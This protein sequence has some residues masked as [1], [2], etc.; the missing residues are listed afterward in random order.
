[1]IAARQPVAPS[2]PD[3][4]SLPGLDGLRAAACLMVFGV[5]FGQITAQQGH[6]GP[7]DLARALANGNTGVALFFALSG[8]LLSLP[9][10]PTH[11]RPQNAPAA[12]PFYLRRAARILPAYALCLAALV[13]ANR[14]WQE[15][16]GALDIL[17][18]ALMV[19]NFR[20]ASTL[21]INPVF[22][23][24]AVE[25]QFYLLLPLLFA[26][27]RRLGR[28]TAWVVLALLV[29]AAWAL[30][31]LRLQ[32]AGAPTAVI[33]YS[34]GAHLP[35]FLL[36]VLTGGLFASHGGGTARGAGW[37]DGAVALVLLALAVIL[38]TPLDEVLQVP[39]GRYN[40]PFVPALLCVLI[41]LVPSSRLGQ[42]LFDSTPMRL[43][44]AVSYG[45]YLFH[46]PVLNVTARAM[47]RVGWPIGTHTLLYGA[48]SLA[49]TLVV[50]TLSYRLIERPVMRAV[51]ARR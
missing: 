25:V 46:L 33:T 28:P 14:H 9:F 2:P 39:A 3:G 18:H 50:A 4:N 15:A 41:F 21:S 42:A 22:W 26:A 1:M 43:I 17:L 16:D 38:S 51:R 5:H 34:L 49:L 40:L 12:G 36:G 44:G 11:Q 35:H 19:F 27:L 20:E 32:A 48:A 8:F 13:V 29:V 23:T 47:N 6:W 24:L 45:V 37:R 10:W 7:F 31:A 30:H